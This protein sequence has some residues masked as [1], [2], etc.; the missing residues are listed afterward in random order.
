MLFR[1]ADLEH[2]YSRTLRRVTQEADAAEI[3]AAWGELEDQARAQLLADGV[4]A[5]D[6][7]VRRAA[8]LHY[9]GQSFELVVPAPAGAIDKDFLDR[10]ADAFGAEH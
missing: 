9:K 10:L 3:A 5:A 7:E 6:M 8:A 1:S 4:A 2:H